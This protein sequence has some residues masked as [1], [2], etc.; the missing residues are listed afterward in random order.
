MSKPSFAAIS[1]YLT[2]IKNKFGLNIIDVV[3]HDDGEFY[4]VNVKKSSLPDFYTIEMINSAVTDLFIEADRFFL[5]LDSKLPKLNR[6]YFDGELMYDRKKRQ[7]EVFVSENLLKIFDSFIEKYRQ[8]INVFVNTENTVTL[9]GNSIEYNFDDDNQTIYLFFDVTSNS[10]SHNGRKIDLN[11][12]SDEDLE[13]FMQSLTD[14]SIQHNISSDLQTDFF[15][16]IKLNNFLIE[17][18][19]EYANFSNYFQLRQIGKVKADDG[20]IGMYSPDS[21]E[22]VL[23]LLQKY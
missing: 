4:D 19:F 6:M 16:A 3:L 7:R 15:N 9:F 8:Y 10:L 11:E 13:D 12:V 17:D 5:M 23:N 2:K 14:L 21:K 20:R 22:V 1:K 18:F